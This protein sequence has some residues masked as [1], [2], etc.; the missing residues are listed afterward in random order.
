V[1]EVVILGAGLTGLSA[2][3]HLE[4]NNFFDYKIF[5]KDSTPGGLL[6]TVQEE[7][8]SFDYTGHLLHISDPCFYA[9]LNSVANIND[10]ELKYRQS[11]I[12]SKN[13]LTE[14]PFQINLYG[15][16]PKIIYECING[17]IK[18]K[19]HK[20]KIQNFHD[21]VLKTFGIGIAKHFLFPFNNKLLCFNLKQVTPS[22]TGRFVP[23]TNLKSILYGALSPKSISN[24]GYNNKFYYPKSGGIQFLVNKIINKLE[25]KIEVNHD[26]KTIDLKTKTIYFENGHQEKFKKLITT[27]P[28]NQF[29]N[30]LV[31]SPN[32]FFKQAS[33][34]LIYNSVINFNL[35]FNVSKLNNKHWIYFPEKNYPFYRVGF[36]HN[37]SPAA[38]KKDCSA[39]Y[40]EMSY[41]ANTKTQKQIDNLTE[42]SINQ[43]ID[44]LHLTSSH[45][46]IKKILYIN[47]A[48]VI[49]D[50]WREKKLKNLLTQLNSHNIYSIG[51][52]GGWKY[53]SMQEAAL[54]GKFVVD[55]ILKV[56]QN[57]KVL[58]TI[59]PITKLKREE[60]RTS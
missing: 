37:L 48:Y 20:K 40:G 33:K 35:G 57:K 55:V 5:E 36:W 12:Y 21:W 22:W 15:L 45:V 30:Y 19:N 28:L 27:I 16:P 44:F 32:T 17:F 60:K 8:F 14:Y 2:A 56:K 24:V 29:L 54:D 23:K 6:K 10:F 7:G 13:V 52:Y 31:E 4:K 11:A 59:I 9:F 1:A 3:Y 34:K 42:K 49:Y 53:S 41:L 43:T 26:A 58:K 25:N 47:H 50:K 51:R 39:I 46:I 38:V 18:R